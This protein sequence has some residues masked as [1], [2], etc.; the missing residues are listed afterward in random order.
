[1]AYYNDAESD[2]TEDVK[3][4]ASSMYSAGFKS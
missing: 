2:N 4:Q 3:S 1:M